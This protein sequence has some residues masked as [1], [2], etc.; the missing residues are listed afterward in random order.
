MN[1][2]DVG[3]VT[4]EKLSLCRI[5]EAA[6][7]IYYTYQK[8]GIWL[9][10]MK[11]EAMEELICSFTNSVYKPTF[12]I[13]LLDGKMIGI[14]SYMWSH[15]SS[16]I[17]ELSF[18]TVHPDYQRKGIGQHLTYLRLKEIVGIGD[19]S[20]TMVTTV[21]RVPQLFEKFNFQTVCKMENEHEEAAY[22]ICKGTELKLE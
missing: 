7:L 6:E 5:D 14:A 1:F 11:E 12:F 3:E 21:A 19:P 10:Y 8:E 20:L 9:E 2:K 16:H 22:M 18:G 17:F 15:C 13:A 4:F